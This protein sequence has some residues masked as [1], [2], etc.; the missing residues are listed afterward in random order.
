MRPWRPVR[1]MAGALF[2]VTFLMGTGLA[3]EPAKPTTTSNVPALKPA[4]PYWIEL[5]APQRAVLEPLADDWER[6]DTQTKKKWVEIARRYPRM[7][8]EEQQRTQQRMREWAMLTPDQRRVARDS[9]ARV[10]AM[11]PEQRAVLLQR[12]RD[13]PDARKSELAKEGRANKTLI[14]PKTE[15]TPSP[16]RGQIRE[17]AQA[18]NPAVIRKAV[19]AKTAARHAAP[20]PPAPVTPAVTTPPPGEPASATPPP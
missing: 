8:A 16:R 3:A 2:A 12:Y 9:F 17:G 20:V 14:V 6:L 1:R 11:T 15:M 7:N 5:E 4:R 10:R 19:E 18:S 13:L